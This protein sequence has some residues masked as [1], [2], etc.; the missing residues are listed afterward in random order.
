MTV[1]AC[2][3]FLQQL[4]P[5]NNNG[6]QWG[7][8]KFW[9][10]AKKKWSVDEGS[11]IHFPFTNTLGL[12][13]EHNSSQMGKLNLRRFG[14]A[15]WDRLILRMN[16]VSKGVKYIGAVIY[17]I[18]FCCDF[19]AVCLQRVLQDESIGGRRLFPRRK[20]LAR[21]KLLLWEEEWP[22][23]WLWDTELVALCMEQCRHGYWGLK[24]GWW[25]MGS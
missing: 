23:G 12:Q 5:I 21:R 1:R 3:V 15:Q 24:N 7:L 11:V 19:N 6:Y 18:W 16:F 8:E 9:Y 10:T 22:W 4:V 2:F 25:G 14:V 20:W 13:G 17:T